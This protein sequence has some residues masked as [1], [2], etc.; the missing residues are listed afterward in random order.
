MKLW[1]VYLVCVTLYHYEDRISELFLEFCSFGPLTNAQTVRFV[2]IKQYF[3]FLKSS[4]G[5]YQRLFLK[6]I[7]LYV[8]MSFGDLDL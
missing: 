8:S 7:N 4:I 2:N 3:V 5:S 6:K 1:Q